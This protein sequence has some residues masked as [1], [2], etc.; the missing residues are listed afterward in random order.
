[1]IVI[2]N[3]GFLTIYI[4]EDTSKYRNHSFK[5]FDYKYY[6][7]LEPSLIIEMKK[8]IEILNLN[9]IEIGGKYI[10]YRI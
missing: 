6:E 4:A 7:T 10:N 9:E 3:N 2:P 8:L 1:M 5:N